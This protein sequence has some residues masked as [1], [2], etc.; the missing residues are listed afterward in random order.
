MGGCAAACRCVCHAGARGWGLAAIL[1]AAAWWQRALILDILLWIT[2]ATVT[3]GL[4]LAC[5]RAV[6]RAHGRSLSLAWTPRTS[7]H[8]AVRAAPWR[9]A[10][11]A[12]LPGDSVVQ[13]P[14]HAPAQPV[15][16]P[17]HNVID[18]GSRRPAA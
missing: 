7:V 6:A 14:A 2:I 9:G 4:G 8:A 17:A 10:A 16:Q 18:L 13:T 5:A 1:A 11:P 12:A 3:A 15:A